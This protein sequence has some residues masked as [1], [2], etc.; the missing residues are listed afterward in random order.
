[1]ATALQAGLAGPQPADH[2]ALHPD[3]RRVV[4]HRR[5]F[6]GIISYM[7]IPHMLRCSDRAGSTGTSR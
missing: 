1:M 4:E 3:V 5:D 7:E 6:F 2:D